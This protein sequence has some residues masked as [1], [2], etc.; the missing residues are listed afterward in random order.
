MANPHSAGALWR[1]RN[2]FSRT[3]CQ[4]GEHV[5]AD[6]FTF[7][8]AGQVHELEMA[9]D[10]VGGWDSA[11][12]KVLSM[13]NNLGL[14]R[15]MLR[16]LA[17]IKPIEHIINL[18][19]DPFTPSGWRVEEHQ[20]GGY[21]RWDP[22]Q[23]RLHISKDQK[24]DKYVVGNA[25]RTELNG[26]SVLNANVLDYLL[27]NPHL[28]PEEWEGRAVFFWGTIYRH[29]NRNLYVRY[30]CWHGDWWGWDSRWLKNDF[31]DYNPAVVR[32]G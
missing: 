13:G 15:D 20:K 21:L 16:G 24:N 19:A 30:L 8:S 1:L 32:A 26:K 2:T 29:S 4:E 31:Y 9:M 17:E 6:K 11:L 3:R 5:M 18:D 27:A 14:V 7:N 25:L 23:V 12:V 28:I 10:R 22:T